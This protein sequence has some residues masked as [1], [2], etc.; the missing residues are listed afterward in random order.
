MV[1]K[2]CSYTRLRHLDVTLQYTER[3]WCICRSTVYHWCYRQIQSEGIA[4]A[5]WVVTLDP[6]PF[7]IH[8]EAHRTFLHVCLNQHTKT[9]ISQAKY[10]DFYYQLKDSAMKKSD[11]LQI[12]KEQGQMVIAS[13]NCEVWNQNAAACPIAQLITMCGAFMAP[14][15]VL[16]RS[17]LHRFRNVNKQHLLVLIFI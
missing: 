7:A 13:S 4:I 5:V 6:V 1:G 2:S 14:V 12:V 17:E 8:W 11:L 15:S 16:L 9:N 3:I 10:S